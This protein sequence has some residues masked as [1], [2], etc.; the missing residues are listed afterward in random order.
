[1]VVHT[2]HVYM[3]QLV[4]LGIEYIILKIPGGNIKEIVFLNMSN[5]M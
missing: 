4:P 2:I 1:M 3:L 5:W